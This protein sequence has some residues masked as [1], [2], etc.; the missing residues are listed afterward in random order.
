M[1]LSW[2]V[3]LYICGTRTHKN[4]K[5]QWEAYEVFIMEPLGSIWLSHLDAISF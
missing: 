3:Y 4:V 1:L 2:T 5:W